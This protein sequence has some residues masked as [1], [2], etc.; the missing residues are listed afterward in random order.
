VVFAFDETVP[1]LF[2]AA[3]C[4]FAAF[5]QLFAGRAQRLANIDYS[6]VADPAA[7]NRWAGLRMLVLPVVSL[8]NLAS[9]FG[10]RSWLRL[11]PWCCGQCLAHAGFSGRRES[12][13]RHF[14]GRLVFVVPISSCGR[15]RCRGTAPLPVRA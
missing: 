4:A 8:L 3:V 2:V 13:A 6:R 14:A 5:S 15:R 1:H 9:G 10:A 12:D 11:R 7:L